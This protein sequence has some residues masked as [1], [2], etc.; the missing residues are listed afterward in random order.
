YY[1]VGVR[2]AN[3][4]DE[5]ALFEKGEPRAGDA[6]RV[7]GVARLARALT[8]RCEL[9]REAASGT[10]A[11]T[12]ATDRR[13]TP[14]T[15][16]HRFPAGDPG[17]GRRRPGAGGPLRALP[18]GDAGPRRALG[19]GDQRSRARGRG[20]RQPAGSDRRAAAR[21]MA[22]RRGLVPRLAR[23]RRAPR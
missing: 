23:P 13:A 22:A 4:V 3:F 11:A 21:R 1:S 12:M 5:V 15:P 20:R 8:T 19:A 7:P 10:V 6:Q 17:N 14:P 16:E 9:P 18:R 2:A